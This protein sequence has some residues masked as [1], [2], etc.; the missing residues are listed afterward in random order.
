MKRALITGINGFVGPYLKSELEKNGY[1]VFGFGS[2]E[3]NQDDY[4]QVD[5]RDSDAVKKIVAEVNPTHVFH[6]AGI[7]APPFAEKH[8]ELAHDV[9]V[10]GTRNLLEALLIL[11]HA[12]RVLIVSSA[13]VYGKPE[14]LPLGEDH[15]MS[16][17]GV[18]TRTRIEQ[19]KVVNEY[20]DK[21]PI[22]VTRSFNH[23]GPGRPDTFVIAKI[24]KHITEI[25][26]GAR[27]H[28]ELGNTDIKRDISD[29]RDVVRAYRLLLEQDKFGIIVN[30]C[31]G[32][33]IA[34][35]K[36]IEYGRVL[37]ELDDLDVRTNPDFVR[38]NDVE[39]M[40]GDSA[41]LKSLVDWQP[42]IGCEQ[43]IKD[44]YMYWSKNKL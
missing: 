20:F 44:I 38:K 21:L 42:E 16:G 22:V 34:L 23:T 27:D 11:V 5:I 2:E 9:N 30:V 39:D 19:E 17:V 13:H 10:L 4:S 12:P 32:E 41:Y 40:Y 24:I 7:S 14:S 36:V 18:Y 8:P 28:L 1:E 29:V 15:P 3:S 43:M 31:R 37:A 26:S 6:L 25:K 35:K 33:S